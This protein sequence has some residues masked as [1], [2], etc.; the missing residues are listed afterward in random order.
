MCVTPPRRLPPLPRLAR[1]LE[2][3]DG[4]TEEACVSG[5]WVP[6]LCKGLPAG[7]RHRLGGSTPCPLPPWN[8]RLSGLEKACPDSLAITPLHRQGNLDPKK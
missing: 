8:H 1:V 7:R 2:A 3:A 5:H 6:V 4:Q